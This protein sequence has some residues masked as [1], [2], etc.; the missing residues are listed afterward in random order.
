MKGSSG[1]KS[2]GS[3]LRNKFPENSLEIREFL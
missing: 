3:S 2:S 1:C